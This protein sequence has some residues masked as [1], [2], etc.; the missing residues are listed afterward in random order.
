MHKDLLYGTL[1]STTREWTD[2]LFTHMLRKIIENVRGEAQKVHWIVFDGDVDPEWV[3]NLNS[4]L[5]D[6]KLLTLP[7][8]ERLSLPNNVRI[9][10]EVDSLQYATPATVSR[11]GMVWFSDA[12]VTHAM[13][14][15]HYLAGLHSVS[16]DATEAAQSQQEEQKGASAA[17]VS[18]CL[19]VQRECHTV[20]EPLFLSTE[21][22][23]LGEG[24]LL[25]VLRQAVQWPHVMDVSTAQL[26]N[27]LVTLVN[28]SVETMHQRNLS[29]P[30]FPLT[31]EQIRSHMGRVIFS[32]A[33]WAFG[34]SLLSH[35]DRDK[36]HKLLGALQ[37]SDPLP[38]PLDEHFATF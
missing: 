5:D 11:C 24:P 22:D 26:F 32:H 34:G 35:D 36:L 8:G 15:K 4:V 31:A 10:F 29:R 16:L 18:A 3:E 12:I 37:M 30:D 7:N 38:E 33:S 2:G 9:L 23:S 13:R 17:P 14:A 27:T 28:G 1:E 21:D 6:N 20:L 25:T 19:A